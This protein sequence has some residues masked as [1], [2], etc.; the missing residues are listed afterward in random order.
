MCLA[1]RTPWLGLASTWLKHQKHMLLLEDPSDV[2][3]SIVTDSFPC[4][5]D[6]RPADAGRIDGIIFLPVFCRAP[7][8]VSNRIGRLFIALPGM[9]GTGDHV[10]EISRRAQAHSHGSCVIGQGVNF[11]LGMVDVGDSQPQLAKVRRFPR[12]DVALSHTRR[13]VPLTAFSGASD[14]DPRP[15]L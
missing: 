6:I 14:P 15:E 3:Q 2:L 9:G 12:A 8:L 1:T 4:R 13:Y 10:S 5:N 11:G 7:W